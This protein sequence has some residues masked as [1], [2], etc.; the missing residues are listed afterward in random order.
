MLKSNNKGNRKKNNS[1]QFKIPAATLKLKIAYIVSRFFDAVFWALPF[2]AIV[3]FSSYF[4]N[5]DRIF[6]TL[7]LLLFATILP[8]VLFWFWFKK[9]KIFDIDFT[10][11][12]ER[13]PYFIVILL[14][15]IAALLLTW[16]LSGPHLVLVLFSDAIIIGGLVIIINLYWKIS[17]HTL[18]ATITGFLITFLYGWNYWWFFLFIPLSFWCRLV[19]KKHTF[20]QLVAGI[21]LGCLF[22]VIL[23][24]FG[25]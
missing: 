19:S 7:G 22:F 6:W 3:V 4:D 17:N 21:G 25:N 12:E 1:I 2:G 15:W 8:L 9:G 14:F 20:W 5:H 16:V 24:L 10:R 23:K 13:T 18:V 11:K